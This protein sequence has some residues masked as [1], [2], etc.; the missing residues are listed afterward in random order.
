MERENRVIVETRRDRRNGKRSNMLCFDLERSRG[1]K[2]LPG[3][4][5]T[6]DTWALA[7]WLERNLLSLALNILEQLQV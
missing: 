6:Y 4:A 5:R 2:G 1:A 7:S 3:G